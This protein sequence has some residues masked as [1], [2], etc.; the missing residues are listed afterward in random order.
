VNRVTSLVDDCWLTTAEAA[1]YTKRAAGT[2][3]A[4][5]AAGV[6]ES[7]SAGRGRGRRYRR[8]WLDAWTAQPGPLRGRTA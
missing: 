3:R 5:A 2:V 7:T 6:L 8:E 4:A 1:A